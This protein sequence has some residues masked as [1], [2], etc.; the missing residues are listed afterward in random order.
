MDKEEKKIKELYSLKDVEYLEKYYQ[1]KVIGVMIDFR[2]KKVIEKIRIK[3]YGKGFYDLKCV[4]K[5][6]T[7]QSV[8]SIISIKSVAERLNLDLPNQVLENLRQ[9]Q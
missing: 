8:T 5:L 1:D 7:Q 3:D 2:S 4:T 6:L 9:S